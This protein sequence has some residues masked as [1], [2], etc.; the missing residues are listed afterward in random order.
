MN[1]NWN[2]LKNELKSYVLKEI[3]EAHVEDNKLIKGIVFA[4]IGMIVAAF[5]GAVIRFFIVTPIK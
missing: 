3:F 5:F 2:D 1:V 4:M